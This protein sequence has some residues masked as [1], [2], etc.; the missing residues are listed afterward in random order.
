MKKILLMLSLCLHTLHSAVIPHE[1]NLPNMPIE[2]ICK[3]IIESETLL[4]ADK[5]LRSLKR[6]SKRLDKILSDKKIAR[7]II[8]QLIHKFYTQDLLGLYYQ[9][10]EFNY[11]G[12]SKVI[13][14]CEDDMACVIYKH[15][16]KEEN[17]NLFKDSPLYWAFQQN[18]IAF[19]Y[20]YL[21]IL[22]KRMLTICNS[23]PV[24]LKIKELLYRELNYIPYEHRGST[25]TILMRAAYDENTNKVR[26]LLTYGAE[27]NFLQEKRR[28]TALFYAMSPVEFANGIISYQLEHI[29]CLIRA[30]ADVNL[31]SEPYKLRIGEDYMEKIKVQVTAIAIAILRG[32]IAAAIIL[33]S[34][35]A[36]V[37][38]PQYINGK[39]MT[40]LDL[41]EL[42]RNYNKSEKT[43]FDKLTSILIKLGVKKSECIIL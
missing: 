40:L 31:Y 36:D 26:L 17:N 14:A 15:I 37:H 3:M 1:N 22:T 16:L 20:M 30:G 43:G 19:M 34:A 2:L 8:D 23:D 38:L 6:V 9:V 27:V 21:Y 33:I 24:K 28:C 7:F 39:K 5:I 12:I 35:G 4:E 11:I 42:G 10:V 13:V 25:A 29:T 41:V 32:N 18:K